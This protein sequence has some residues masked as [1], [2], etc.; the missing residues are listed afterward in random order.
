MG[1]APPGER[2]TGASADGL[3]IDPIGMTFDPTAHRRHHHHLAHSDLAAKWVGL[4][5]VAMVI[6]EVE[7]IQVEAGVGEIPVA[8]LVGVV[9]VGQGCGLQTTRQEIVTSI[10]QASRSS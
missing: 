3:V 2:R 6:G 8:H 5:A 1:E 10:R 9:G 4:A 7:Q